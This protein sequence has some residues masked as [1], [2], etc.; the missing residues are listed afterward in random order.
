MH[1]ISKDSPA[2]FFTVVT[3]GRLPVF[4]TNTL[5]TIACQAL[6][7]ARRSGGF[8]IYA[9]AIMP[10]HIHLITDPVRKPSDTLRFINGIIARQVI[11]YLKENNLE[12]SLNK[13]RREHDDDDHKYSLW[14]HHSNTH[15]ITTEPGLM[16]K[17][18][19]IHQNPVADGLCERAEE[20][21]FSSARY[22]MGKPLLEA[23]PLEGDIKKID[24][25]R[26][27]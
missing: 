22:W 16:Q 23:E 11:D 1:R 12:S 5:K 15:L 17:V 8:A 9:Y 26:A 27:R 3:K 19:Y 14:E 18:N 7:D 24:W 10:D 25:W 20:Y 4:R 6:N 2:Y 13:L 21:K